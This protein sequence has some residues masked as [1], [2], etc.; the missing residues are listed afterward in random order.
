[1][2]KYFLIF[3]SLIISNLC[4]A[5]SA[6]IKDLVNIKGDRT[7]ELLGFG[8]VVGLSG[9]GDSPASVASIEATRSMLS[10][11]GFNLDQNLI[12]TQAV[13]AV[14]VTAKLPTFARPGDRLDVKVSILGDATSLAG[15][16]L[17]TSLLKASDGE[18]YA[19]AQGQVVT[20][21][22][23]GVGASSLT[24]ASVPL[25]GQ[26]EK[27]FSPSFVD[28]QGVIE[29]SLKRPD[30]TTSARISQ[31]INQHFRGFVAI[32]SNP[33]LIEVE[34]PERYVN[35]TVDFISELESLEVA[36]DQKALI[37]MNEKTGTIVM[38]GDVRVSKVVLSHQGLSIQVG[39]G[40]QAQDE[41]LV[42][43]EGTT[44]RELVESLNAMG[45]K[46]RDLIS[47]IQS[48]HASGA[49]HADI[50]YL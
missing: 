19:T 5:N 22:A 21:Q 4:L 43:V 13:A 28:E 39:E 48:M 9:T 1:M 50:K 14:A 49:L 47:I 44:V 40:A 32:A 10:R 34:V 26:V 16:T 35:Q 45:V 12:L 23:S 3:M 42:P 41:S 6:K 36:V 20:A 17:M 30:F 8:L 25:G 11:L 7:N 29:L 15:G 2:N 38:G 31:V 33:A 27:D 46:P 24:V 18:V 37:V